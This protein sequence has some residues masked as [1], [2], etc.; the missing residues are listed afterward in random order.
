[1]LGPVLLAFAPF[2]AMC[3]LRV[4]LRASL[5]LAGVAGL[6]VDLFSDD[7]MGLHALNYAGTAGILYGVKKRLSH[8]EPLHLGLYTGG[9]S[10][11]STLLQLFLLFLFDRRVPFSGK[12]ALVDVFCMPIVDGVY[13]L[14]WIAAPL[15]ALQRLRYKWDIYWVKKKNLSRTSH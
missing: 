10:F 9:I 15:L 11:I 14:V 12:W 3:L 2:M 1:M 8:E 6:C 7:P 4:S 5:W 13:A